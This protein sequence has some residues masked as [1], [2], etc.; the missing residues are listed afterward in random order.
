MLMG[1]SGAIV[2]EGPDAAGFSPQHHLAFSSNGGDGTLSV[3]DTAAGYKTV[4]TL[5]TQKG[6]RTMSYD[7]VMDRVYVVTAEF[8]PRPAATPSAPRP[9]PSVVPDSFTV[10]VEGR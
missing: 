5:A 10:L 3:V 4:Q 9:R 1:L 2:V 8:G 7:D 6:A